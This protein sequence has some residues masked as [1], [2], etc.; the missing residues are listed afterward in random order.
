[1]MYENEREYN[2]DWNEGRWHGHGTW[3]NPNGDQYEGSFVYDTRHG[4]GVY[5]W[6][7][8]NVYKGEFY[9][10]KRQGKVGIKDNIIYTYL[11]ELESL[12][13]R[14]FVLYDRSRER[15]RNGKYTFGN[16][17]YEGQWRRGKY[18]GNGYLLF[19]DGSSYRGTFVDGVAH[20]E[21]EEISAEGTVKK[22]YW[23]QGR[24]PA[25]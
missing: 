11:P 8:G 10:D 5:S 9:E 17:F 25:T 14:V 21:G 24:S 2:G 7:N 18:H 13:S 4:Q 6:R 22:G 19:S 16:G 23:N 3:V 1:M 15:S 20:G 12:T